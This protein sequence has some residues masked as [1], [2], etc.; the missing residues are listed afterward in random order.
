MHSCQEWINEGS[1]RL[2]SGGVE[3]M[4]QKHCEKYSAEHADITIFPS[5][6]MKEWCDLK[7]WKCNNPKVIPYHYKT[8]K[9]YDKSGEREKII[10]LCFFG[11]LE[12]RKGIEIF[13]KA[14]ELLKGKINKNSLPKITL[15]GKTGMVGS[16]KSEDYIREFCLNS[17]IE[18]SIQNNFTSEEALEYLCV[19]GRCAV[20][21]TIQ[22]NLPYVVIECVERSIPLIASRV[23][24]IPEI[25]ES[26]NHL[27]EP[28]PQA[29]AD[30]M[31][32]VIE[33]GI[34]EP[35]KNYS[36]DK[37]AAGWD[38]ISQQIP[39]NK[40]SNHWKAS[41]V[42]ICI[43]YYNYGK[44]L[45][46][47]LSSL[48]RQ[49]VSGFAIIVV[50]DEST[51]NF[52]NKVFEDLKYK[53]RGNDSWVFLNKKNGGIG[54]TRNHAASHA[55]TDLIV[56]MD[57]DNE[58]EEN[59]I[60]NMICG[61]NASHADC[62]TC[63]MTGFA[64]DNEGDKDLVYS[65]APTG[66]PLEA[67]IFT[68]CLGD[69]NFIIK[70]EVFQKLGGFNTERNT[71]YEDWEFLLHLLLEGYSLDVIPENLFLYR[72]TEVGFSRNTSVAL[73][74]LRVINRL[75]N[76]LP[77]YAFSAIKDLYS[78]INPC[79]NP[80]HIISNNRKNTNKTTSKPLI[81]RIFYVL[82]GDFEEKN[83]VENNINS[84]K[85]PGIIN[86]L[87]FPK[88]HYVIFNMSER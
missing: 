41:D 35:V 15:M 9:H 28:N 21:P 76:Y 75:K 18:L 36:A 50:N 79:A 58:A 10:E 12:T 26:K 57:A 59:M 19:K 38:L 27:F 78:V 56:F 13:L 4:L 81:K 74:H 80:V 55:K 22:D 51:D 46:L 16:I 43:A 65:Y 1:L 84:M 73:N 49:T 83:Y 14:I 85:I 87:S 8:E 39:N 31:Y 86:W 68:N 62:L 25:I 37:A 20:I 5:Q 29:L 47:L 3:Y 63:H 69:A 77:S 32:D 82:S 23:G 54:E 70:R 30:K 11:R 40:A 44:Y 42:T 72:H 64:D 34:A 88:I 48:D 2:P 6:Y 71:S 33:N 60:Y 66:G 7:Q 61:M 17:N 53:Y 67:G 45:P 24:G 52:S